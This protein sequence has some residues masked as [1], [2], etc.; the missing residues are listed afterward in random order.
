MVIWIGFNAGAEDIQG[1]RLHP[2]FTLTAAFALLSLLPLMAGRKLGGSALVSFGLALVF[3]VV[4]GFNA[5]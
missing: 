2:L 4:A 3:A 1:L 5:V